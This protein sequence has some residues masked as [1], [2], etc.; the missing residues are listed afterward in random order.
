MGRNMDFD[1]IYRQYAPQVFRVCMGYTNDHDQAKDLT[2]ETFILVW[3]HLGSF[4]GDSGVGTWIFRIATNNCLRAY[5]R[6]QRVKVTSM[7][8]AA[9]VLENA[10]DT[11]GY[12]DTSGSLDAREAERREEKKRR[13]LY[14]CIADLAE[15]DRIIISLVLE[16]VPQADIAS[17]VGLSAANTRVRI[18]RI[19]EK[20]ALQFKQHGQF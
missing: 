19:K 17:I 1:D 20:L 15:T 4:R 12:P 3:R 14:T 8:P 2:Q 6:S 16:D 11:V 10:P 5:E 18:H 7:D 9:P 13:F